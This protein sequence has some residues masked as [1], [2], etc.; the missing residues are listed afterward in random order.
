[1]IR[2][3]KFEFEFVTQIEICRYPVLSKNQF[4]RLLEDPT[5]YIQCV[6]HCS[7]TKKDWCTVVPLRNTM[8]SMRNRLI[9]CE[10]GRLFK[11]RNM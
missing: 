6:L 10:F 9:R 11:N 5:I 8:S 3:L 2:E 4:T 7:G 1:M